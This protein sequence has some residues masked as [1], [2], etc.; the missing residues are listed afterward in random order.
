MPLLDEIFAKYQSFLLIKESDFLQRKINNFDLNL[1]TII[2]QIE[3]LKATQEKIKNC[4]GE[5]AVIRKDNYIIVEGKN[6]LERK[7]YSFGDLVEIIRRLRD[8]DGCP[9]DIKQTNMSIRHNAVEEAYELAEAV[10]LGD[11]EKIKEESG[12]VM[13]QG[14][15]HSVIAESDFRFTTNDMVS[16]LCKKL[17]ERHTHVF[18]ENK[19]SSSQDALYF[20]EQA[21]AKEKSHFTVRDKL[22]AVPKTYGSVMRALKVQKI[23]KKTGFEFASLDDAE[24]KI[25]EEIKEL[26]AAKGQDREKEGGDLLFSVINILR[27]MKIDPEL[28]LNGTIKRFTERF[29][30][31]EEMAKKSGKKLEECSLEQ[32]EEWYQQS[33]KYENRQTKA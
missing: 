26:K 12:D 19:A 30:Y 4:F 16:D 15:F 14:L 20:W 32:M 2:Y 23:V 5:A 1:P 6:F 17:L 27:M 9:W 25:Y 7:R 10:E 13:L 21:K 18:G 29:S 11:D 3:D 33:K 24:D 22:A 8:K 28:A 31:V